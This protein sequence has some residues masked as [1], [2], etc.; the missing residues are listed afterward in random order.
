MPVHAS[1]S[2]RVITACAQFYQALPSRVQSGIQGVG[3]SVVAL[4]AAYASL[5]AFRSGHCS[6]FCSERIILPACKGGVEPTVLFAGVLPLTA[7]LAAEKAR[8]CFRDCFLL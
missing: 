2:Q 4:G 1:P 3:Y 7:G 8:Q 6:I 5:E